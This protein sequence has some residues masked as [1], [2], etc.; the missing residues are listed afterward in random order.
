MI[1]LPDKLSLGLRRTLSLVPNKTFHVCGLPVII[2]AQSGGQGVRH[3][4]RD[5]ATGR[6]I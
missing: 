4:I 6:T 3:S 1:L 2:H 5:L